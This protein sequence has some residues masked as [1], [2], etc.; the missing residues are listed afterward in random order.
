MAPF[1]LPSAREAPEVSWSNGPGLAWI[2]ILILAL[3][4]ADV[5]RDVA[6]V[7]NLGSTYALLSIDA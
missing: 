2:V 4:V 5:E 1:T 6:T 7:S 3:A